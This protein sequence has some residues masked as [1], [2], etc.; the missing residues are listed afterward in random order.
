SGSDYGIT[1][2]GAEGV[3]IDDVTF[4]GGLRNAIRGFRTAEFTVQNCN[5]TI[6]SAGTGIYVNTHDTSSE[7]ILTALNN[8]IAAGTGIGGTEN[9]TI[10]VEGNTFNTS[11]EAIGL[12]E[13]VNVEG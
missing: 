12:G 1:V 5:I 4:V 11:I 7:V 8:N 13:G 3:V 10:K 9:S 6:G 2:D